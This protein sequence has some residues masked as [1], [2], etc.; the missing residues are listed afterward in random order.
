[1]VAGVEGMGAV[2]ARIADIQARIQSVSGTPAGGIAG[3]SATAPATEAG[4]FSDLLASAQASTGAGGLLSSA[5][6]YSAGGTPASI[7]ASGDMRSTAARRQFATDLLAQLGMPQTSE[8]VRAVMAWQE[9]EGTRAAFNPL[10]TTQRSD[11]A[12]DFNSVGVKNYT[13]YSQ[14]LAATVTT[15]RNGRYDE[16]LAALRSGTSADAVAA[17][18]ARSPWGTG[19]GVARVLDGL[20]SGIS[21]T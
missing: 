15:L 13:S 4:S 9:A 6:V 14:G 18:V 2:H 12:S 16:I 21:P 17:A 11:G 20:P 8:N 7:P 1:M 3:A 19:A 10:A 5:S